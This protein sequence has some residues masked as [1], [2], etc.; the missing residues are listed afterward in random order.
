MVSCTLGDCIAFRVFNVI[1]TCKA[2]K[3][4]ALLVVFD[5]LVN[6]LAHCF[7]HPDFHVENVT[8]EVSGHSSVFFTLFFV[9]YGTIF[10]ANL[11]SLPPE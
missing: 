9:A 4:M 11:F 10:H 6:S 8:L 5:S 1:M 7:L 2:K 3:K